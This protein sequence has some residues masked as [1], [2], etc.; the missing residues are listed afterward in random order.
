FA[1]HVPPNWDVDEHAPNGPTHAA[2]T[3][4]TKARRM[5]IIGTPDRA[6]ESIPQD[7]RGGAATKSST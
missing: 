2:A 4:A 7:E 5:F 3:I 1:D 6:A